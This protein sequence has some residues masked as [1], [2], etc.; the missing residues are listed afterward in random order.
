MFVSFSKTMTKVGGFRFGIGTR[1]TKKN[2]VWATFIALFIWSFQMIW[3]MLV[4]A[5]WIM[6]AVFYCLYLVIR[7]SIPFFIKLFK[8]IKN[9]QKKEGEQA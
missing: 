8:T 3:Y 4:F 7:K 1:I 5:F 9:K 2:A 6:Y